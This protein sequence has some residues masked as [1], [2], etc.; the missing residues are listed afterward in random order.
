MTLSRRQVLKTLSAVGVLAST[1][2]IGN[3]FAALCGGKT[4]AQTEGPFYPIEDQ[5]DK[6]SDLTFVNGKLGKAQG[7]VIYIGGTVMDENCQPVS[8]AVVEIWQACHTGRY[9]HPSDTNPADLDTNFQYW[10]QATTDGYGNYLFKTVLPGA[11]Q[12][13]PDWMRPP[14]IHFKV[15]KLGFRELTSQ[16]YFSEFADLNSRDLILRG[17]RPSEQQKVIV[18]LNDSSPDRES[19]SKSGEFNI[20]ISAVR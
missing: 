17:L 19:G 6:D 4:P 11:Y 18:E 9:N 2:V 10:G 1:S 8:G 20:V 14:H 16:L 12:A 13:S 5:L 3:A 15:H 7:Q